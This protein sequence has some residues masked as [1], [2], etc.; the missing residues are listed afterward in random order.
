MATD[1]HEDFCLWHG[2][3][4]PVLGR[5]RASRHTD[6]FRE[7]PLSETPHSSTRD[8]LPARAPD[9]LHTPS[10]LFPA[11]P[12]Q[13]ACP[14]QPQGVVSAPAAEFPGPSTFPRRG[15]KGSGRAGQQARGP[16]RAPPPPDL[17]CLLARAPPTPRLQDLRERGFPLFPRQAPERGAQDPGRHP[18]SPSSRTHG[19]APGFPALEKLGAN[20]REYT[21]SF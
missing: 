13:E 5:C 4:Y 2:A 16:V 11:P 20:G 15:A 7:L 9:S 21:A 1:T 3:K 6:E 12:S 17:R 10:E 8:R 18:F 19:T 14:T